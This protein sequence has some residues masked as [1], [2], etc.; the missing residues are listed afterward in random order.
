MTPNVNSDVTKDQSCSA[1]IRETSS[2]S[3]WEVEQT[4]N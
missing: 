1:I 2:Y 4:H 3:K